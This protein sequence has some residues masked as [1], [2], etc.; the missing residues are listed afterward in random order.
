MN[1]LL[2]QASRSHELPSNEHGSVFV[3]IAL[4]LCLDAYGC[5]KLAGVFLLCAQVGKDMLGR[6][7]HLC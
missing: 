1:D 2:V 6:R 5:W 7:F 3:L 4:W